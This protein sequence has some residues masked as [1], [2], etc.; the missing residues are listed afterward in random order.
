MHAW[1]K[2]PPAVLSFP[3]KLCSFTL[4]PGHWL[5]GSGPWIPEG[6]LHWPIAFLLWAGL[7]LTST[8]VDVLQLAFSW[9]GALSAHLPA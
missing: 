7:F 5:F 4:D 2:S 1:Q 8:W 6:H 9:S 3:S